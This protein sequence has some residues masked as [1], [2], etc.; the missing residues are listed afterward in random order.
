MSRA[1][2]TP[3]AIAGREHWAVCNTVLLAGAGIPGGA[4][5]GASDRLAAA[6]ARDPVGP[7]D[8]SATIYHLLNVDPRIELHDRLNKPSLLCDGQ[9]ISAILK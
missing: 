1:T 6:P 3:G 7:E 9:V 8:L 5:H 4:V 2:T